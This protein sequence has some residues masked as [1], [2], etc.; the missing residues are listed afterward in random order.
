MSVSISK[1]VWKRARARGTDLVILLCLADFADED[2]VAAPS[3]ATIAHQ[4]RIVPRSV[5]K[6]L[7][8]LKRSGQIREAGRGP[9]GV[10]RYRVTLSPGTD[11]APDTPADQSTCPTG[12]PTPVPTA[13]ADWRDP[14]FPLPDDPVRAAWHLWNAFAEQ[15]DRPIIPKL[16][17]ERYDKIAARLDHCDGIEGWR[18]LLIK[19]EGRRGLRARIKPDMILRG[20]TF[21]DLMWERHDAWS[22]W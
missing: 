8:K 14:S 22:P 17:A 12:H 11:A 21:A 10:V 16:T 4:A 7:A 2:G 6:C 9:K 19:A 5:A 18:A 3:V 20:N 13:S 15:H 1:A